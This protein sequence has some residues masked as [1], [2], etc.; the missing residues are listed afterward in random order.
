M[1]HHVLYGGEKFYSAFK[2]P[3]GIH[4]L[5]LFKLPVYISDDGTVLGADCAVI[6]T[7]AVMLA[8]APNGDTTTRKICV[9]YADEE[10][11]RRAEAMAAHVQ[12]VCE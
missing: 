7:M 2:S 8:C 12:L 6:G 3:A 1:A 11:V 9:G 10:L 4:G 5:P